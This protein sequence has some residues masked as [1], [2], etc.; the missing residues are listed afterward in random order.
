M[1]KLTFYAP[2]NNLSFGNI[3]YNFLKEFYKRNFS[4]SF[5]P[6]GEGLNVSAFDKIDPDFKNWIES[7]VKG[8]YLTVDPEDPTIKMWHI[9]QGENRITPR[10][11]LYT[12]YELDQPTEVEKNLVSLQ[13]KTIFSSSYASDSFTR[14]GCSNT[15]SI[16]VG[17]DTDFFETGKTYLKDRVHFVLMGKFEKRKHTAKIIEM[18]AQKYGNNKDYQ[19]SCC[20]TNPFFKPEQMQQIIANSLKGKTYF[21]IN[22]LPYLNTNSEVNELMNSADIDLT[23]LSGAE[24]WNLPSFNMSCLGKWSIVLNAS[25]HLDWATQD[26]SF[27]VQPTGKIPSEDGVFFKS[28]QDFNQG[29]I[30]DFDTEDALAQ[31]E[32]AVEKCKSPNEEG[33]KLKDSF[34]YSNTIDKILEVVD[35]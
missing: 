14:A 16:P 27:L 5:F 22:F 30:Y 33:R 6:I 18:W 1:R 10:Q 19:L 11:Y 13:N 9:V 23:G 20:V 24:G 4:L 12:F 25:S 2:L 17:F 8:R 7:S 29:N 3:T 28:G 32:K 15:C 34:S 31:I 35:S 21:N 26:N